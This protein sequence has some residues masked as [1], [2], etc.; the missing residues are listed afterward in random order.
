MSAYDDP[1][2][3]A[4][5]KR[6]AAGP[7]GEQLAK[8]PLRFAA[9]VLIGPTRRSRMFRLTS[10]TATLLRLAGRPLAVTCSHVIESYRNRDPGDAAGFWLGDL[11]GC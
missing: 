4:K 9:G 2:A 8:Y 7:L 1:E 3:V 5:A 10:G 6:L 11:A